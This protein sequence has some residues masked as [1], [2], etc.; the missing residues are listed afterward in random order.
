MKILLVDILSP[1]GHKNFNYRTLDILNSICTVDTAFEK[2]YLDEYDN[3]YSKINNRF[4][5]PD[6]LLPNGLKCK[7]KFLYKLMYRI[8]FFRAMR[9]VERLNKEENYDLTIFSSVDIIAFSLAVYRL[10]KRYVFID[11]AI[12]EI[13]KSEI[14]KILWRHIN[15]NAEVVVMEK[16]IQEYLIDTIGINNKTWLIRHPLP[17]KMNGQIQREYGIKIIFAPSGTNDENFISF[18]INNHN[19]IKDFKIIIKSKKKSYESTSLEVYSNRI[20]GQEYTNLMN[21]C[22]YVLL[23]YGPEYN[24][25]VSGVF[26]E[27]VAYGKKSIIKT[28]NTLRYYTTEYPNNV[29]GF[30]DG[31]EFINLISENKIINEKIDEKEWSNITTNYSDAKLKKDYTKLIQ[32][33]DEEDD[34]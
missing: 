4:D 22:D 32:G 23:P 24:Y 15:K 27:A 8:R 33:K 20:S 12:A 6:K 9:W 31:E 21:S 26:F 28:N 3:T 14:K 10:N 7:I 13:N 29:I 2:G 18:L 30:A 1:K 19:R 11:H 16:Y 5:I 25:R 34:K 17:Q